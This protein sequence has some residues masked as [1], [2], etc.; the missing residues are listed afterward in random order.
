MRKLRYVPKPKTLVHITCR[1]INGLYLF[2]PGPEFNDVLLGVLGKAQRDCGVD[3][4]AVSVLSSH[5]HL[6]SVVDDVK[7]AADFMRNFKSKLALETNR[8]TDWSGAVFDRRYEMAVVTDEE[9]AQVEVFK[10]ILAQGVKEQLVERILDWPGVHSFGALLEGTPLI[11]HWFDRSQEHAAQIRGEKYDRLQ[12]A[13]VEPVTLSP[14]PCWAHLSAKTYRQRVASLG[15]DIEAEAAVA[16][17][18]AGTQVVGVDAILARD[19]LY[20]PEKL[21]RSPAP[22]VHAATQ[23]ARKAFYEAYSWFVAAFRDAA[24]K[25]RRGDRAAP[26]PAGS[27]PPALPFVA[28]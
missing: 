7:Q 3:L 23:A 8:L 18:A 19:P 11:G 9:A 22:R 26:F 16:R 28:G 5:F 12:Y 13:T 24:E 27:F 4:C 21:A 6:L 25:L 15:E 17:E 20:R 10:Y 1:T 14:L 2:R